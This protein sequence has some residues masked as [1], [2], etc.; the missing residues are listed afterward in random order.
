MVHPAELDHEI[1]IIGAGI[2]GIGMAIKL[3]EAGMHDFLLLE[4]SSEVGGTWRDNRYPGVAVDIP[5]CSY[6]YSFEANAEWTREYAQG[7]EIQAYITHCVE[8]Y[9]IYSH[10]Q[11]NRTVDSV[12]FQQQTHSWIV[13]FNDGQQMQARYV[14]SATG[15]LSQ[16]SYP[17]ID[18]L[19]TF[20][21]PCHH[22]ARWDETIDCSNKMIAVIGTGASAVQVIPTIAPYA[23]HL[24]VF[25]RTPIWVIPKADK[26]ISQSRKTLFKRLPLAQKS[27]RFL[28]DSYLE[29]ATFVAVNYSKLAFL[30]HW[31]ERFCLAYLKEQVPDEALRQKLTPS[32]GFACKRPA[33]SSE[34]LNAYNR[35]NV[36]LI[37]DGISTITPEG[38]MT[39]DGRLHK[40]D[41][42]ILATGFKT[43]EAGNAPSF[44]VSGQ[45]GVELH[46]FWAQNRYQAYNGVSV[47]AFPNFFLTFGPY[48]AGLNWF[49]M[50]E[51]N[52]KHILRC[53]KKAKREHATFIEVKP[54]AQKRYFQLMQKKSKGAIFSSRSCHSAR[55]YYVDAHGDA[56]LPAPYIPGFRRLRSH[57]L[58]LTAYRFEK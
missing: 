32:Y 25:Q 52:V 31:I 3:K 11:F 27:Y 50:L 9:H 58:P 30:T 45:N 42:L 1:V 33:I 22:T 26:E 24:S 51:N 37:T 39:D 16:P 21:G 17:D 34:Y 49:T 18:G 7:H 48:S 41:I 40:C 8:K 12:T 28:V 20:S 53:L 29:V 56:S 36:T 44:S 19:N 43:L 47:P 2:S 6:A 10:I 14:I 46:T 15:V 5:S 4:Q 13:R 55:S 38:I 35:E 54:E 57:F 23:R